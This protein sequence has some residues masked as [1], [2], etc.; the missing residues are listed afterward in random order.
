MSK[1]CKLV[2]MLSSTHDGEVVAAARAIER[3]LKA[4]GQDWH[5][6]VKKITGQVMLPPNHPNR[7]REEIQVAI[8]TN[9][10][11]RSRFGPK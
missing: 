3:E 1:L 6:L 11:A 5:W 8:N 2:L 9:W 4:D 7:L 10:V